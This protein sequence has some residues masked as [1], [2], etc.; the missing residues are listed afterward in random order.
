MRVV[1]QL[2]EH[3]VWYG[4]KHTNMSIRY[5]LDRLLAWCCRAQNENPKPSNSCSFL[6]LSSVSAEICT[7]DVH[8]SD[9]SVSYLLLCD[10]KISKT[11][12]IIDSKHFKI[13]P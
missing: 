10:H 5:G 11:Q 9:L 12:H 6:C 2:Y 1:D 4:T 7:L 13:D 8:I 3:T